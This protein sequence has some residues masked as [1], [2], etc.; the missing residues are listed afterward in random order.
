MPSPPRKQADQSAPADLRLDTRQSSI[1]QTGG[2]SGNSD[3][4]QFFSP[5]LQ[6][7][8]L[9][10]LGG[11]RVLKVLG[12]GGM[13]CVFLAH[14]ESLDRQVALK[15][16][17]PDAMSRPGAKERFL[18]EGKAA[19]KL[20]HDNII[21]IYQVGEDRG[22]PFLALEYLEGQPLDQ[23]LRDQG[24]LTLAHVIRIGIETAEGLKAAHERGL[25]HRD[26][27]PANIWL[28]TRPATGSRSGG[29]K[30]A[31]PFRVKI[32]DFGLARQTEDDT[33]LTQSGTVVGTPAYMSP[34]QAPRSGHRRPQ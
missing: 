23:Y 2:R 13:G 12:Q 1:D 10:R 6:E 32:L 7:G 17:R 22:I 24:T 33:H 11:Y 8:E 31:S 20:K 18:R 29:A 4:A 9:G 21:T 28:E 25:V 19:A 15:V 26:I 5:P 14:D 16:M 30:S 3:P 34:E 27:K